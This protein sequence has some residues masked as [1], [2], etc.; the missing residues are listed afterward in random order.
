MFRNAIVLLVIMATCISA[1]FAQCD[2]VVTENQPYI[3]DFESD[4][5]NCWTMDS[6]SSGSWSPIQG[7]TTT[8]AYFSYESSYVDAEARLISPVL[9]LSGVSGAVLTFEYAMLGNELSACYRSSETDT[10]HTLDTYSVFDY[11]NTYEAT[12][13]LPDLSATYQIS[14]FGRGTGGYYIFIDNIQVSSAQTCIRPSELEIVENNSTD[15]LIS[16]TAHSNETSWVLNV[17]GVD[18]NITANPYRLTG[19]SPQ[20]YYSV[21]IKALCSENNESSWSNTLNFTT[22]CGVI[23][24]TDEHPYTDDFESSEE[25]VCWQSEIISGTDNWVVDPGYLH[26]NH[27]AFF[28]WLG[29]D[30]ML[31][32]APLD[33]STV[34]N[35][36]LA[37][38]RKQTEGS[39]YTDEL[40]VWYRTSA[41][42][43]WTLL[44]AFPNP[45]EGFETEILPLPN[46]SATYYIAFEGRANNAEGIYVDDVEVGAANAVSVND[47]EMS[48]RIRLYPNPTSGNVT[49]ESN[50]SQAD[51]TVF[52]ML[53]RPIL[54]SIITDGHSEL[55][56]SNFDAGIYVIRIANVHSVNNIKVVKE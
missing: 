34:T 31:I 11:S 8:V 17:D 40:Y 42:D 23:P 44:S 56:F 47:N 45:T 6:V 16:W 1:S 33:I 37:F 46:P 9:D 35:P 15:V 36:T 21:K 26:P 48:S 10:W 13:P 12:L 39:Q 7:S 25:F 38:K 43:D 32:S 4:F 20:T 22:A 28:I 54:R 53:G 18:R 14:F 24:V 30:A 52:D 41:T 51:I 19:L 5:M 3:E 49:L 55:D 2:A 50:L 27:T 29:G